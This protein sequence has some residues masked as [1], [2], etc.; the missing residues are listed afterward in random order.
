LDAL[1]NLFKTKKDIESENRLKK[2]V[3]ANDFVNV[4][5]IDG[6]IV[7]T[8]DN[9]LFTFISIKPFS[10][11][12]LSEQEQRIRGR[13][14]T[15]EFS[16]LKIPY[17]LLSNSR[18]VDVSF[19]LD[20]LNNIYTSTRDIK[21]RELIKHKMAEINQIAMS[22]DITEHVFYMAIWTDDKKDAHREL[23]KQAA[24]IMSRFKACQTEVSLC[25]RE[26]IVRLFNLFA[27]PN[28][29]HMENGDTRDYMPFIRD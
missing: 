11:E 19:M 17:K 5:N 3:T 2:L 10:L 23:L 6:S 27:N 24:E 26:E 9:K 13:Q 20:N 29:T 18:P 15:A 8:K 4:R 21:R 25:K 28:Y 14:F 7:Y 22:S 1:K 16:A 12:L